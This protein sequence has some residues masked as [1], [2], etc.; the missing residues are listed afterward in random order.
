MMKLFFNYST[1]ILHI[2]SININIIDGI[3]TGGNYAEITII[4][5]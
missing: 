3:P 2:V 1:S 4:L 5:Y